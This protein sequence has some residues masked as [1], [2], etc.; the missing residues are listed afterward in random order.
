MARQTPDLKM[1]VRL[2]YDA[3]KQR[4]PG[5]ENNPH[6]DARTGR[7]VQKPDDLTFD[8]VQG[9]EMPLSTNGQHD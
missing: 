3:E 6:R 2:L 4:G 1:D 8:N 5:G 9:E 7:L